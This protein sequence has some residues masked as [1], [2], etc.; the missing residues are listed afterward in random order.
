LLGGI[1]GSIT[2]VL[3]RNPALLTLLLVPF[4]IPILIFGVSAA[5][6][7]MLGTSPWPHLAL[8]GA[9]LAVLLP[10]APFIIAAAL[11]QGQS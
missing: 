6:A 3:D 10:T 4:Y 9:I 11:R 7:A 1:A 8:L 5:D 2:V